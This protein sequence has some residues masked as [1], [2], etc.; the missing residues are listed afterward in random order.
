MKFLKRVGIFLLLLVAIFLIAGIFAPSNMKME[1]EI[2]INRSKQ[3]IFD[4]IVLL[5][6]QENY[7]KWE[8][9]D[10]NMKKTYSGTDGTVGFVSAWDSKND[11]AGVGEQ[12]IVKITPGERIDYE[13]RFKEP[14]EATNKAHLR[15]ESINENQTK[16]YW[17][18]EGDTPYPF[19]TLAWL[20]NMKEMIGKDF[21]YGLVHLKEILEKK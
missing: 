8:S 15:L 14:M 12:E 5:K 4:Y 6:N 17:G 9:I 7:S 18:F 21:D 19:N 3:A 1:R 20:F 13:L 10:P 11:E 16:V 2:T